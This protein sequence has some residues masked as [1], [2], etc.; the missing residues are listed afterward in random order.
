MKQKLL[1]LA[2]SS[3][4][5]SPCLPLAFAQDGEIDGKRIDNARVD[6]NPVSPPGEVEPAFAYPL[7][8]GV[9]KRDADAMRAANANL[10]QQPAL[11]RKSY[12]DTMT[13]ALF[14]SGRDFLTDISRAELD[15][16]AALLRGK[17]ESKSLRCRPYR[18]SAPVGKFTKS[19]P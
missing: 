17:E 13:G 18:Q 9:T 16:L 15:K 11:V 19:F 3:C 14:V 4:F 5:L 10:P 12:A 6:L 1:A 7:P 2:I 8:S